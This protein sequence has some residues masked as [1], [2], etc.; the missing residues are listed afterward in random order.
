MLPFVHSNSH[1]PPHTLR[2]FA[3]PFMWIWTEFTDKHTL[4]SHSM[5]TLLAQGRIWNM[6]TDF[7]IIQNIQGDHSISEV[8][9]KNSE[10][11]DFS[12]SF[13][14]CT[15]VFGDDW[16]QQEPIG[17][18]Q[19]KCMKASCVW[20]MRRYPCFHYSSLNNHV[21]QQSRDAAAVKQNSQWIFGHIFND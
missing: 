19:S 1:S 10:E 6:H 5:T 2:I 4:W 14:G 11:F 7:K 13:W 17:H 20:M 12:W 15:K 16:W 3:S 18:W 9:F 8:D 21:Q